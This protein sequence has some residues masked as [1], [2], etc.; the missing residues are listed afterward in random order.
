MKVFRKMFALAVSV[1]AIAMATS[2]FAATAEYDATNVLVKVADTSV[3]NNEAGQAT[4][5]VVPTNFGE[6]GTDAQIY[7]IDQN[8]A[9]VIAENLEAGLKIK[10]AITVPTDYQVRVAGTNTAMQ[11]INF[12]SIQE[13]SITKVGDANAVG[14]TGTFQYNGGTKKVLLTFKDGTATGD[15]TW[16]LGDAITAS[17]ATIVF[18]LEIQP[19]AG[20]DVSG[21]ELVS[22]ADAQ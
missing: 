14:F 17:N 20:Q 16:D 19:D 21:I 15:Y 9:D 7:F 22:I 3:L 13:S 18:G 12:K 11:A 8:T 5:A 1:A 10:D 6:N 4:V 2:A